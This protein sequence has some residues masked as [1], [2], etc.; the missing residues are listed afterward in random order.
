M[1][2]FEIDHF[3]IWVDCG[4]SNSHYINGN[5]FATKE[6]AQTWI[7]E[8]PGYCERHKREWVSAKPSAL[9]KARYVSF[10]G[11]LNGAA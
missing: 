2:D 11:I 9:G 6:A 3:E 1:E 7:D 4:N 8:N 5:Q 10:S